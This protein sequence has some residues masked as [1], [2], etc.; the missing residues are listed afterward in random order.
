[1][2]SHHFR[3]IFNILFS[4]QKIF[5]KRDKTEERAKSWSEEIQYI[6][7]GKGLLGQ[8]DQR[9]SYCY[10]FYILSLDAKITQGCQFLCENKI[11]NKF[12]FHAGVEF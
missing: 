12:S 7:K 4:T 6:E 3:T 1:M 9:T 11:K 5:D 2:E 10:L 8:R